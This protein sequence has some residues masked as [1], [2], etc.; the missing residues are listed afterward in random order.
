MNSIW[1]KN[2]A[3]FKTRFP[4]LADIFQ[5]EIKDFE[6]GK[7]VSSLQ[8]I[9]AKNG[10]PTVLENGTPLHSKYN[11][12]REASQLVQKESSQDL[13]SAVFL[14]F[15]L[16][17]GPAEFAK[18]FSSV[19]LVL[20]EPDPLY[21]LTAFATVDWE[22]ILSHPKVIFAVGTDPATAMNL[23]NNFGSKIKYFSSAPQTAHNQNYFDEV[24]ALGIRSKQKDEINTNT[25]EKFSHLWLK[26]S[27][28]NLQFLDT[29]DGVKKFFGLALSSSEK[30]DLPFVVIAAGP[31]LEKI[32]PH[33]AE[34]KKRAVLVCV[35]TALK[36]CLEVGVEPDF[37]VLVDPQYA[38][39]MHLEFLE[40]PSSILIAESAVWPSVFRFKC[41]EIIMCSSLFPI[42]K[43]FEKML[44]NKGE[45]GAGGSVTTTAWDFARKCGAKR[46]YLAGMDLGFPGKQTHIRGSQFEERSHRTSRRITTAE[47]DGINALF[48]ANPKILKDYLGGNILTDSRMSMFSWWFENSAAT[49]LLDGQKTF[50]LTPE[51]LAIKGIEIGDLTELLSE[52][53]KTVEK[54]D[55]F[56]KAESASEILKKNKTV[57][58]TQAL[59]SF[60][61][62]LDELET[63]AK[64][65]LQLCKKGFQDSSNLNKT[66]GLL[67]EVDNQILTSK[68]K[69]AAALVF[70][71]NRQLEKLSADL[72]K[73]G[74]LAPLYMSR[75]IYSQLQKA[76]KEYQE[77]FRK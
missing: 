4:Q 24:K 55:F 42:G 28:K 63:L 61:E 71:T 39:A 38:C 54:E 50:T 77:A 5:Q 68:A 8:I 74:P 34:L 67:Q 37:I 52:N 25:L 3:S 47:T 12:S 14:G 33:L 19:P 13:D 26:N 9:E 46:I 20:V 51:S 48:G 56:N 29:Q 57:S 45:L 44:G 69:D 11:P 75:L 6:S 64:K 60:L 58:Y 21:L 59:N 7:T 15:G 35:D 23:A 2:I 73:S 49:A 70:P 36:A 30:K 62:N 40:S 16:G 10:E 18:N 76:V 41:K 53:E 72:P 22:P 43:Y 31:S 32:L 17:Y 66:F 65:G 27:C 1:N